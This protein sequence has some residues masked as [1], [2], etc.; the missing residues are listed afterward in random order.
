MVQLFVSKL[1]FY[2]VGPVVVPSAGHEEPVIL[3]KLSVLTVTPGDIENPRVSIFQRPAAPPAS[4]SGV[5]KTHWCSV[6]MSRFFA[7]FQF[8][9]L[10]RQ[11]W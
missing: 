10:A 3:T 1:F 8:L 5:S 9:K 6:Q 7:S 11:L 2:L 4:A